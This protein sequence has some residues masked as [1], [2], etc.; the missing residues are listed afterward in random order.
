MIRRC[1]PEGGGDPRLPGA[2]RRPGDAAALRLGHR[3]HPGDGQRSSARTTRLEGHRSGRRRYGQRGQRSAASSCKT[4]PTSRPRT[5]TPEAAQHHPDPPQGPGNAAGAP[6]QILVYQVPIAGAAAQAGAARDRDAAS[7]HAL[8]RLR[9][10]AASP[11]TRTS[12]ATAEIAKHLRLSD[13]WSTGAIVTAP[14]ADPQVR[15]SRRCT[16]RRP[17]SS[18]APAARSASMPSRRTHRGR[19]AW[20]S[21]THPFEVQSLVTSAC[22]PSAARDDSFLDEIITRRRRAGACSSAPTATT[23]PSARPPATRATEA[24]YDSRGDAET[25]SLIDT[26]ARPAATAQVA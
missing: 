8:R 13:L 4:S 16:A 26:I 11:S 14:S 12:P 3:R 6:G 1:D 17:Y 19:R 2:V 10:D 21:R 15:Q 9:P 18:S 23:A 5:R 20:T 7:L 25:R 22:S 24:R